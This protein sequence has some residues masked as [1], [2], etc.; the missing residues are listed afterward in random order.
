[1]IGAV[2]DT[3]NTNF[4]I[5]EGAMYHLQRNM[6]RPLLE[7]PCGHHVEQLPPPAVAEAVS[8]RESSGPTDPLLAKWK[9]GWNLVQEAL[10]DP[11]VIYRTF[12][13]EAEAGTERGRM[14]K[15]VLQWAR[16]AKRDMQFSRGDYLDTLNLLLL[17]LGEKF[18]CNMPRP[19]AVSKARFLQIGLY[20]LQMFLLSDMPIVQQILTQEEL[21]EVEIMAD[22]VAL[23]NVAYMLQAKFGERSPRLTLTAIHNLRCIREEQNLVATTA[24]QKREGHLNWLSP[25]LV[26]FALFDDEVEREERQAMAEKLL[27]C[28]GQ[29]EPGDRLIYQRS[30]PGPNFCLG[31]AYWQRGRPGLETFVNGR[32]F[33]L[34]EVTDRTTKIVSCIISSIGD[35]V[36]PQ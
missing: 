13:W 31:D 19:C 15:E 7:I 4:G 14:A 22:F 27:S 5:E 24:L 2:A 1:M 34:W 29:W 30:V 6:D 3:T 21:R 12:D 23:H 18:E 16:K 33:L 10:D 32:S 35:E 17:F 8:G 20:Y 26:I 28:L 9:A 36:R 11:D 25:E